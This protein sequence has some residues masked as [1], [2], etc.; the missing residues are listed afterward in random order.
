M[1]F[2]LSNC[3]QDVAF[4]TIKASMQ[5]LV[6]SQYNKSNWILKF[7]K[8][9]NFECPFM[10]Y[11]SICF[12]W[13]RA[14]ISYLRGSRPKRS[15]IYNIWA[16]FL[17]AC[18]RHLSFLLLRALNIIVCLIIDIFKKIQ[19]MEAPLVVGS[20]IWSSMITL[21]RQI[22]VPSG[23]IIISRCSW[24]RVQPVL[25]DFQMLPSVFY[26]LPYRHDRTRLK[27]VL[28]VEL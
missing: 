5:T 13:N 10:L 4:I 6:L 25:C 22:V 23:Y 11:L 17:C 20:R 28:F 3:V 2:K 14:V 12:N 15:S 24:G 21:W 7:W 18:F 27:S 8:P 26:C 9:G 16:L 1:I 19:K